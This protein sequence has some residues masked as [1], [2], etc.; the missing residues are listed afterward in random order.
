MSTD[1]LTD[2]TADHLQRLA[3]VKLLA[4]DVDGT[5]SDGKLWYGS[6][7]KEIKPFNVLDGFGMKA[8]R[9]HAVEVALVTARDSPTVVARAR[10]LGL[11]HVQQ[12]ARDKHDALSHLCHGLDLKLDQVAYMGDDLLDLPALRIAGF[13]AAPANAHPF[14]RRYVHWVTRS[15]GGEGAVRELCDAILMAQ[16]KLEPL[17]KRYL[18]G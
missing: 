4:L 11:R 8:L 2:L 7:G 9:E 15:R 16:G 5:M 1:Y 10:D 3:K 14:V 13:A 6:D 12:G 17:V 18:P